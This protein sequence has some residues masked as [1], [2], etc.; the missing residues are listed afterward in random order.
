MRIFV[1]GPTGYIGSAVAAAFAR[2]GHSVSGLVRTQEGA[3]RIRH[4]EITPIIGDLAKPDTYLKAIKNAEVIV[5]CAF[6]YSKN[7]VTTEGTAI[8]AI[9]EG[10]RVAGTST[11]AILYT[12]GVWT[13]GNTGE[14]VADE[15]TPKHSLEEVKWRLGIEDRLFQ[16]S[17]RHLRTVV[18]SPG[19]V[20]GGSGGLTAMWFA[21]AQEG[22]VE[23]VGDGQNRWAMVHRDDLA[24]AYVM[25]AEQEISGLALYL[26]DDSRNSVEEMAL[27]VA[28][29]TGIPGKLHSIS[30]RE[31]EKNYGKLTQ[32]LLIDQQVSS[33]RARRLLGWQPRHKNFITDVDLYYQSWKTGK[34]EKA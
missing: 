4:D 2:A 15:A 23:I 28:Q 20:Y 8:G 6:D 22:A 7:G 17:S 18:L 32:G 33:D 26:T 10:T 3:D 21:S 27:A 1:T 9:L 11:R 30:E 12:S 25:A 19:C 31:A 34:T 29:A 5:H 16:A 24:Q 13:I 14:K